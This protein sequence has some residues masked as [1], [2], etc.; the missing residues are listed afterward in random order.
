MESHEAIGI[1]G[2]AAVFQHAASDRVEGLV[3]LT[4]RLDEDAESARL[5]GDASTGRLKVLEVAAA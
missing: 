5:A 1:A 4:A 2:R 3:T